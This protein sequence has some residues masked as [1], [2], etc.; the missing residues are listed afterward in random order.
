MNHSDSKSKDAL[1]LGVHRHFR[2]IKGESRRFYVL[3][4]KL[5]CMLAWRKVYGVSKTD[6]YRY[7]LLVVEHNATV[8]KEGPSQVAV[9]CR[10]SKQ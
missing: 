3:E 7:K 1:R 10:Q 6:F 2:R 5:V 9:N 4:G 8:G